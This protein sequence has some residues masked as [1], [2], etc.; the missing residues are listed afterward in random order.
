MGS[1]LVL[2]SKVPLLQGGDL[3]GRYKAT[4]PPMPGNLR[5]QFPYVKAI[6][7]GMGITIIE[8]EGF[9]ADDVIAHPGEAVRR[10]RTSRSPS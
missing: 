9:E 8:K 3:V 2:D 10:A 4:R 6:V 5:L 7:E 1:S